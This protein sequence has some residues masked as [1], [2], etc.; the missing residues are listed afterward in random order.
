MQTAKRCSS[1]QCHVASY[2][3]RRTRQLQ[4]Q[5]RQQRVLDAPLGARQASQQVGEHTGQ[6]IQRELRRRCKGGRSC[7]LGAVVATVIGVGGYV[8][9]LGFGGGSE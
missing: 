3:Q 2:R 6:L 5:P 7:S 9:G 8:C 4:R 1:V